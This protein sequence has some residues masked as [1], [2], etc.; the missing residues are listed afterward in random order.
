MIFVTLVT[1]AYEMLQ[2]SG[3]YILNTYHVILSLPSKSYANFMA[4]MK[5]DIP[6]WIVKLDNSSNWISNSK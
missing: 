3:D 2:L 1:L 5:L 4:Y 6:T